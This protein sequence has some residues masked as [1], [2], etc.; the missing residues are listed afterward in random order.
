MI[1]GPLKN[2]RMVHEDYLLCYS[3]VSHEKKGYSR[4]NWRRYTL[5]LSSLFEIRGSY[6]IGRSMGWWKRACT[7]TVQQA[8]SNWESCI[9]SPAWPS[10]PASP[11][12][13][14]APLLL[15]LSSWG[16]G[17]ASPLLHVP[18]SQP[19]PVWGAAPL[20]LSLSSHCWRVDPWSPVLGLCTPLS[21]I[22][23]I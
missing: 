5:M 18:P 3:P 11:K 2:F 20:L 17:P 15:S 7:K 12:V 8:T 19:P 23:G 1:A 13:G 16:W 9:S 10:V 4:G 6:L 14:A 22:W 21:S